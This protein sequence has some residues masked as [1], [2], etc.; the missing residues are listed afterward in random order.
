[1]VTLH[2]SII[3][4]EMIADIAEQSVRDSYTF[5]QKLKLKKNEETIAHQI[6]KE[7]KSLKEASDVSSCSVCSPFLTY[8]LGTN[9][10]CH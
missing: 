1:K 2:N 7:I 9:L 6:L 5:F 4:N 8:Q 10:A 3:R